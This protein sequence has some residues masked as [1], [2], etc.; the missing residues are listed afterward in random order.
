MHE[1]C[2]EAEVELVKL[3]K[4]PSIFIEDKTQG[5]KVKVQLPKLLLEEIDCFISV[6]VLK[7]HAIMTVTLSIK[8]LWG[9]VPD[10]MRYLH[11]QNLA[12]KLALIMKSVN[13][14]IVVIDGIYGLDGHGPMY[15]E[16]VKMNLIVTSNNPVVADAFGASIMVFSPNKIGHIKIVEKEGL[17]T[18]NLEEVRVNRDWKQYERQFHVK[19]TFMDR[20]S[21]LPFKSDFIAKMVFDS[22]LT[23]LIY[24]VA[25]MLKKHKVELN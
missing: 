1:I 22:S 5:K 9:C 20:I 19:K 2:R 25:N 14:K 4:L 21:I 6:P 17:G 15:G 7:V 10:T 12:H 18:T 24:K 13:P 16:P 3:S 11:H 8:N 23:P